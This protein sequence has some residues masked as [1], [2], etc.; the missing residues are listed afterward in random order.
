VKKRQREGVV[1]AL[2]AGD[3]LVLDET[4]DAHHLI[5]RL[6]LVPVHRFDRVTLEY[7]TT[8]VLGALVRGREPVWGRRVTWR[9]RRRCSTF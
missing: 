3:T 9:S 7:R 8:P 1:V 4:G 6:V 2:Q 5:P